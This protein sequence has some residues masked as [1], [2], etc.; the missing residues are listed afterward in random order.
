MGIEPAYINLNQFTKPMRAAVDDIIEYASAKSGENVYIKLDE[1]LGRHKLG[2]EYKSLVGM[3][4]SERNE[5]EYFCADEDTCSIRARPQRLDPEDGN[6]REPV[7]QDMFE[8][9]A[10][11][12]TLFA[13]NETGGE[14]ADFVYKEFAGVDF[15]KS[16]FSKLSFSHS[17]FKDCDLSGGIFDSCRFQYAV[18][19]G[20]K[21]RGADFRGSDF[22]CSRIADTD[23]TDSDF[24]HSSM[25]DAIFSGSDMGGADFAGSNLGGAIFRNG[26]NLE[27]TA[28]D[29][30][31][32][33]FEIKGQDNAPSHPMNL[34]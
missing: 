13:H 28:M 31:H 26:C 21:M 17:V 19:Y 29:G 8:V 25:A 3:M 24:S 10:A 33:D 14:A 2:E 11:K 30:S 23:C 4:L 1:Y 16:G 34:A 12:H 22:F 5:L 27:K 18:F 7:S 20:C 15:R 32:G 9:I 6:G